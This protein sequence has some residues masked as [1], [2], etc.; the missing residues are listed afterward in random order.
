MVGV[1][2]R[3]IYKHKREKKNSKPRKERVQRGFV[4][5]VQKYDNKIWQDTKKSRGSREK[6]NIKKKQKNHLQDK[7]TNQ[8]YKRIVKKNKK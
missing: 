2:P 8:Q 7:P 3:L 5:R 4:W 6:K 1:R